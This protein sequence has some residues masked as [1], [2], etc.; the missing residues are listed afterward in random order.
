[1]FQNTHRHFNHEGGKEMLNQEPV[2]PINALSKKFG[3]GS[4]FRTWRAVVGGV[5]LFCGFTLSLGSVPLTYAESSILEIPSGTDGD[6][7][8]FTLYEGNNV[9]YFSAGVGIEERQAAYPAYP[10]K[11]IF[12]QGARAFLAEVSISIAD[13]DGKAVVEIP[14][15]HVM[16]PWL[17][18]N[19]P[20]GT[21]TI[22]ATDSLQRP[23]EK[24]VKVGGTGTKVIHFRWP[25]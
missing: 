11:L 12:V 17:F 8:K 22:T 25:A 23:I 19:L 6:T 2:K 4:R 16:G 20:S 3:G 14:S 1:M 5:L 24:Q 18:V 9:Q 13:A 10:L 21:Y 7:L 15:D